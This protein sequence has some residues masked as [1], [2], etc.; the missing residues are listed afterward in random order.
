MDTNPEPRARPPIYREDGW[1]PD[2]QEGF[3]VALIE[4]GSVQTAVNA[5]DRHITSAYRLRLR[6]PAFARAWDAARR[7]AYARVR[8]EA[9]DRALNGT[10]QEVWHDGQ[11]I[12]MKR[13]R[14]DNLLIALLN[15]LKHET[16]PHAL[17]SAF[18]DD[19]EDRRTDA[20]ARA[21]ALLAAPPPPPPPVRLRPARGR[22]VTIGVTTAEPALH[23]HPPP[24]G[25]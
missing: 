7:L 25:L 9:M 14:S 13:V 24:P 17:A 15:H 11:W 18:A 10:A 2:V 1:T 6:E 8:D 20:T 19:I 23:G 16:P 4:H 21:L 22:S 5:V 12:G 3:I